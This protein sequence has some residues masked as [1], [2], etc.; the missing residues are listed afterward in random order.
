MKDVNELFFLSQTT[1]ILQCTYFLSSF[2]NIL[3]VWLVKWDD[4]FLFSSIENL[5]VSDKHERLIS[6]LASLTLN[7]TTN[8]DHIQNWKALI[9]TDECPIKY[10]FLCH[11]KTKIW[12]SKGQAQVLKFISSSI[13]CGASEAVI[14]VAFLRL[15]AVAHTLQNAATTC[16]KSQNQSWPSKVLQLESCENY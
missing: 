6:P 9:Y 7:Y 2:C 12:N 5:H 10:L 11:V 14:F 4:F 13:A 3:P 8:I 16:T 1:E 15:K